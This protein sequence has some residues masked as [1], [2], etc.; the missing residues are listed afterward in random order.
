MKAIFL[1]SDGSSKK[2]S[3]PSRMGVLSKVNDKLAV[4]PILCYFE[5]RLTLEQEGSVSSCF[6]FTQ[7]QYWCLR[8]TRTFT[9]KP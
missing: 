3:F 2:L 7:W 4:E 9:G 8:Q 5:G 1:Y 6:E